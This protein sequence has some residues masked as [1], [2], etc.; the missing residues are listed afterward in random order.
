[1]NGGNSPVLTHGLLDVVVFLVEE[2]RLWGTPASVV[3][4]MDLVAV[5]PGPRAQ[6]Q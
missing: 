6:T 3:W 2:H 5:L 1:M 4:H